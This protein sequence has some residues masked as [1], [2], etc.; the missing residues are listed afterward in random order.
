[1]T[2]TQTQRNSNVEH[3]GSARIRTARVS[4][5]P[6]IKKL[7]DVCAAKDQL[8]ARSLAEIYSRVREFWV[9][10]DPEEGVVG[11]VALR[12]V[13]GDLAELRSL[14]IEEG[15]RSYGYG[16][17]L[18]QAVLDEARRLD[19]PKVFALTYIPEFFKKRGFVEV[20]KESL[21]HKVWSDCVNCPKFPHCDEVALMYYIDAEENS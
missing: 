10:D 4:D 8:L 12:V 2:E 14:A 13:W 11:C 15:H 21:P 9:V 17:Q 1:M 16:R 7:I 19:L 20:P 5:A 6:A 18:T 3:L